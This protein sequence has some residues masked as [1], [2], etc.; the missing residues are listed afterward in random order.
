M[1]GT[2]DGQNTT[3]PIAC[4]RAHSPAGQEQFLVPSLPDTLGYLVRHEQSCAETVYRRR[5]LTKTGEDGIKRA[6]KKRHSPSDRPKRR[7]LTRQVWS[8]DDV[9]S[10]QSR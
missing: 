10:L 3:P 8:V 4:A 6:M 1:C 2:G 7:Q 9:D 5:G